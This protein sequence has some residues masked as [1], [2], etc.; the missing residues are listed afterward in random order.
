MKRLLSLLLIGLVISFNGHGTHAAQM[1]SYEIVEAERSKKRK[2]IR[3]Q[4]RMEQAERERVADKQRKLNE[5]LADKQRKLNEYLLSSVEKGNQAEVVRSLKYK[6]DINTQDCNGNTPLIVAAFHGYTNIVKTL[7]MNGADVNKENVNRDT[8]LM[9]ARNIDIVWLLLCSKRIMNINHCNKDGYT[10]L[11]WFTLDKKDDM[12][13]LLR[14]ACIKEGLP[15]K[16]HDQ[17]IQEQKNVNA[18]MCDEPKNNDEQDPVFELTE[19]FEKG[20]EGLG[21]KENQDPMPEKCLGKE[22]SGG[23]RKKRKILGD[24]N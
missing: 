4:Q 20:F 15:Y 17:L 18:M 22:E 12:A 2:Q 14:D 1:S 16:E 7:L 11:D 5:Y 13:Q 19:E 9:W 8:A 23:L 10:A 21:Q 24:S 6:A 3:R